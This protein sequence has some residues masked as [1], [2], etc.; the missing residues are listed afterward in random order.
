MD[1]FRSRKSE[2][3]DKMHDYFYHNLGQ[4]ME[5]VAA[6]GSTLDFS[7]TEELSFAGAHLY[8]YSYIYDQ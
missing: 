7:P 1:I 3:G 5:V 8:A 6:D 4:A 2:G